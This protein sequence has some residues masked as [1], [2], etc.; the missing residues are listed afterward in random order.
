MKPPMRLVD[1]ARFSASLRKGLGAAKDT[2]PI[3]YDEAAGFERFAAVI[4]AP[5]IGIT[6]AASASKAAA[7]TGLKAGLS[8]K[9]IAGFVA[10]TTIATGSIYVATRPSAPPPV[11]A[12]APAPVESAAPRVEPKVAELTP[13]RAPIDAPTPSAK[14]SAAPSASVDPKQRMKA[15]MAQYAELKA[16]NDPARALQLA[17][18]GHARFPGG[19]FW[20]EREMIAISALA[21]LGRRDEAKKRADAFIAAHPESMYSDALREQFKTP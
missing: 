10:A 19:T 6:V 5:A 3:D 11:V 9:L 13:A 15:E 20:Q 2:P 8:F 7:A 18:E 12:Q 16:A 14:P 1:D 17:N 21:R 4:A